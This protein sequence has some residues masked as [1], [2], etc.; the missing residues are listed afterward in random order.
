MHI[1]EGILSAPVLISGVA[2]TAA[3]TAIG[4]KRMEYDRIPEVAL[5]SAGFFVASLIH[6]P[7]GP[8]SAHLI[9]NGLLGLF[10]GWATF[11]AILIG[12][13]L[14]AVLFQYGGFT[15]LGVNCFNMALPGILCHY[16]FRYGARSQKP[17]LSLS[18]SFLCGFG[19]VLLGIFMVAISLVLTGRSFLDVSKLLL[20][21]H[22]PVMVVEG[23]IT[24]FCV[25]FIKKVKP[26][27]LEEIYAR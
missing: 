14:Q 2:L 27:L 22:F 18:A 7:L 26:E 21:A 11:P 24:L 10:L 25:S 3:G 15:S 4:L 8:A 9:L 19:A 20:I 6:I 12:L 13:T 1:S 23:I 16:A 5:F 17:A